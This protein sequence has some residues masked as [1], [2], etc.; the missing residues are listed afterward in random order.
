MGLETLS[1]DELERYA[2]HLVLPEIDEAGQA[3]IAK[4]RVVLAGLGGIGTQVLPALVGAGVGWLGL[5][6]PDIVARDNL[7]RQTIYQTNQLGT[8]KVDAAKVFAY[9]LNPHVTVKR[10]QD[11]FPP[12][13]NSNIDVVVDGTDT[14]TARLAVAQTCLNAGVPLISASAIGY[15]GQVFVQAAEGLPCYACWV[16]QQSEPEQRCADAGIF[17]PCAQLTGA[18]AATLV[19]RRL[20]QND[21]SNRLWLL[22]TRQ[23]RTISLTVPAQPDCSLCSKRV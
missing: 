18:W 15:D 12:V 2:R 8:A 1:D 7:N 13:I 16:G 9:Q 3:K 19:I 17:G 5:Y 11:R 20:L 14:K 4:G 6:D 23:L 10:W 22:D 21:D